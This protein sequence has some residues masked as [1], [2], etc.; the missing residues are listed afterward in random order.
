MQLK[1][2]YFYFK[3]AIS[4]EQCKKIIDLGKSQIEEDKKLGIATHGTTGGNREKQS[5][6]DNAVPLNDKTYSELKNI[7]NEDVYVRD[8][9]ISWLD[10]KWLYELV[11]PFIQKANISSGWNYE[12]DCSEKF[13]FTTYNPGGFYGWHSDSGMC[14][15][16]KYK[17]I[18]PGITPENEDG[19]YRSDYTKDTWKIGKIRKLSV[20]INLNL[21]GEYEGGNLKFDYGPHV[22]GERYHEC[23]EI[24][25]QGSIIVFPSFIAHQVTPITKGT[26]YSLVLWSLGQPFN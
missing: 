10:N 2:S 15:Y 24:R 14:H 22:E 5:L 16:S 13:Q 18:I 12:W 8:S 3:S 7:P 20:T 21:P 11:H 1:N 4:P 19:S 6:N 9:E 23:T 26:R 17:R 25:P